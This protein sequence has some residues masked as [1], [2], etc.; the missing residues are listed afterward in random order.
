[1]TRPL[2]A[3]ALLGLFSAVV[4]S[5]LIADQRSVDAETAGCRWNRVPATPTPTPSTTVID[6]TDFVDRD[7]DG[8]PD[9]WGS[10]TDYKRDDCRRFTGPSGG[11]SL[12]K[13]VIRPTATNR[14]AKREE[15]ADVSIQRVFH[16]APG[17]IYSAQAD[18][19]IRNYPWTG[20]E[21]D[22]FRGRLKLQP[23]SSIPCTFDQF[24]IEHQANICISEDQDHDTTTGV[25]RCTVY[26]RR[27]PGWKTVAVTTDPLPEGTRY[28]LVA[29]RVREQQSDSAWG[30]GRLT[31]IVLYR[32]R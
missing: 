20:D 31:R 12:V 3:K 18:V 8:V 27:T 5:V 14:Y 17:Q 21:E 6:Q 19:D 30:N 7:G 32:D 28:L 15:S 2:I 13:Q 11:D 25:E 22:D 24:G 26:D 1:M 23:C 16:A 9:R 4:T 29:W 10:S